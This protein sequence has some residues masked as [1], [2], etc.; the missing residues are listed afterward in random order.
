MTN[1]PF[2]LRRSSRIHRTIDGLVQT[3]CSNCGKIIAKESRI[4][5]DG[6]L[7]GVEMSDTPFERIVKIL[8]EFESP[9]GRSFRTENDLELMVS[10]HLQTHG[11]NNTRQKVDTRKG[12]RYDIICRC[13]SGKDVCIEL[14]KKAVT[15]DTRQLD[16]YHRKYPGGL[17][18]VCWRAVEAFREVFEQV[19]EQSPTPVALVEV[20]RRYS[21]S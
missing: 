6:C 17:I 2:C 10:A 9:G 13:N 1:C 3:T 20:S 14:K 7:E 15:N 4:E 5:R 16:R 8:N 18:V 19:K 11:I 12:D 21:I